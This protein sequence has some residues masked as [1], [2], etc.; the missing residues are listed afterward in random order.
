MI[1]GREI[2]KPFSSDSGE[3]YARIYRFDLPQNYTIVAIRWFGS[4]SS[5]QIQN[6]HR[7]Y[8][9]VV[10]QGVESGEYKKGR[11]I[12]LGDITS[13]EGKFELSDWF[14]NVFA[15][16]CILLGMT[17]A[18]AVDPEQDV[19]STMSIEEV[20]DNVLEL[21]GVGY[22]RLSSLPKAVEWVYTVI[23]GCKLSEDVVYYDDEKEEEVQVLQSRINTQGVEIKNLRNANKDYKLASLRLRRFEKKLKLA[24]TIAV[25]F[26]VLSNAFWGYLNWSN[27]QFFKRELKK[28][29][30]QIELL[31]RRL[32]K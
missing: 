2:M 1:I 4:P 32:K 12:Y 14:T 31:E 29:K 25:V 13:F 8:F 21:G 28:Q 26:G 11:V 16:A 18:L 23:I 17:Q 5:R 15:P 24:T 19:L 9:E 20:Q 6:V 10:K 7:F 22:R 3:V 30:Q 27:T